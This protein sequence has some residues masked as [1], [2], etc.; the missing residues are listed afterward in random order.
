[1]G[2]RVDLAEGEIIIVGE[3]FRGSISESQIIRYIEVDASN[4][5]A[6]DKRNIGMRSA[7]GDIFLFLDDDCIPRQDW[8]MRHLDW[9]SQG[10]LVVGGAVEFTHQNYWQLADNISAFH[11]LMYYT[12]GGYRSYLSTTNLSVRRVVVDSTGF[13]E[14]HQNRAEDLEWT[15]RFRA[16]GFRLFFDPEA[17]VVHNPNRR[18][19]ASVNEHWVVDAPATLRIRL[20]YANMLNTP[21]LVRYRNLYLWGSPVIAAWATARVFSHPISLW[22]YWRTIPAVYWTK[23]V[24]CWSAYRDFPHGRI[25]R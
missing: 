10:K 11:D 12:K 9:H 22:K 18:S 19:I 3:R 14:P 25:Y 20:K 2:Q 6:S 17:V 8:T 13:M 16:S 5:F 7:Q 4:R 24:W 15:A 23:L 1:M 21:R